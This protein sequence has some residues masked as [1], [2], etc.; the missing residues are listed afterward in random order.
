[1]KRDQFEHVLR[2]AG[3]I[4]DRSE[5]LVLGSQAIHAHLDGEI[6]PASER[7]MEADL[8]LLGD[9]GRFAD[10]IEG[11]IGEASMFHATFGYYAHGAQESTAI[12]PAGWKERL[13]RFETPATNGVVGLCLD[14]HDLWIAKAVANRSK[15]REF[16]DWLVQQGIVDAHQLTARLALTDIDPARREI[17]AGRIARAL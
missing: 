11:A 2:A 7:S 6:P 17:V 16:C 4:V 9:D 5:I 1:M 3:A 13:H 12:L 10:V 15:D 14:V 8:G